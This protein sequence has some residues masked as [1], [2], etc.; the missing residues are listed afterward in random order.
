[1]QFSFWEEN[2]YKSNQSMLVI[3][4]GI[5]GLSTAIELKLSDPS[6]S[7]IVVEKYRK[8]S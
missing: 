4:S 3:G 8:Y 2:Y 1:M 6:L 5:V 7:V